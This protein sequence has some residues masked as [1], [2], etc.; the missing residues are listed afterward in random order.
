MVLK[1]LQETMDQKDVTVA[2]LAAKTMMSTR[3]IDNAKRG[4]GVSLN[5][6]K[7]IAIGLK[8]KLED[9]V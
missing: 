9:L 3:T 6:G 4:R 7:R 2:E 5:T 8:M 1:K